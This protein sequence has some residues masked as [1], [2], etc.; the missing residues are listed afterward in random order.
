LEAANPGE[1]LLHCERYSGPIHL[2]LT[3]VVMPA[4]RGSRIGSP[5]EAAPPRHQ[6]PLYGYAAEMRAAGK[7]MYE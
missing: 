1:A 3:D 2:L 4:I 5:R 6:S 7:V